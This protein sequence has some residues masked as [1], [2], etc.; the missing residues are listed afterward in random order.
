MKIY[1]NKYVNKKNLLYRLLFIFIGTKKIKRIDGEIE[2]I[3][4]I[5]I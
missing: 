2:M 1:I 3:N 5:K 4:F